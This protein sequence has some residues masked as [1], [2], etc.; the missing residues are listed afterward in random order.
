MDVTYARRCDACGATWSSTS[1]DT[2]CVD[3]PALALLADLPDEVLAEVQ[4]LVL[5]ERIFQATRVMWEASRPRHS[6][7][8]AIIAVGMLCET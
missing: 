7:R 4:E 2:D 8:A 5:V 3:C 6:L 1:P